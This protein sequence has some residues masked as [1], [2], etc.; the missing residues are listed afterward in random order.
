M[1]TILIVLLVGTALCIT[2]EKV[3]THKPTYED[4]PPEYYGTDPATGKHQA[5][6]KMTKKELAE[7][8]KRQSKYTKKQRQKANAD[9]IINLEDN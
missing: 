8:Q 6:G 2:I 7:L 4:F 3:G 1:I 5:A 9:R